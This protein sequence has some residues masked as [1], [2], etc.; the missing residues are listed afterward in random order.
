ME[1]KGEGAGPHLIGEGFTLRQRR[2]F[3]NQK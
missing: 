2:A 3:Q 1:G